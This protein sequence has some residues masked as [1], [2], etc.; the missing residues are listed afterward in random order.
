MSVM[1]A[2]DRL[3]SS[4]GAT[5]VI[6]R[7]PC[8]PGPRYLESH[9]VPA[10]TLFLALDAWYNIIAHL[11]IR[12]QHYRHRAMLEPNRET[13]E[14]LTVLR[15]IIADVQATIS[16]ERRGVR[17]WHESALRSLQAHAKITIGTFDDMFGNV[18]RE[19]QDISTALDHEVQLVIGAVTIQVH[20]RTC[21]E[22][23]CA[24]QFLTSVRTPPT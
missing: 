13:F 20:P 18:L 14:P 11:S 3:P 6:G 2:D 21:T 9:I 8:K 23:D 4:I 24:E 19:V 1:R 17:E 7:T 5:G 22:H 15:R 10:L 12:L 16:R